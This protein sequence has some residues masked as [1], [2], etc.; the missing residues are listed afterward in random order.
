M[1][2]LKTRDQVK[3]EDTWDLTQI[4][5]TEEDWKAACRRVEQRVPELN[6][7]VGQLNSAAQV[8]SCMDMVMT[9]KRDVECVM[10]YASLLG[11]TDLGDSQCQQLRAEATNLI[12]KLAMGIAFITPELSA[13]SDAFLQSCLTDPT[14]AEYDMDFRRL[15]REKAHI[16][17]DAEEKL[18]ARGTPLWEDV[19]NIYEKLES[20]DIT[21][22]TARDSNKEPHLVTH[23]SYGKLMESPDRVLRRNTHISMFG[24]FMGL[25][26]TCAATLN[27]QVKQH[28][29]F[30]EIRS[31]KNTLE[32]AL[33]H[34][35]IDE[36][37][38]HTLILSTEKNAHLLHKYMEIRQRQLKLNEM[39]M[40]DLHVPLVPDLAMKFSYDEA[41]EMILKAFKP[42]GDDYVQ[43]LRAGMTT[44]R[45]VDKYENKGKRSGAFSSGCYDTL[46]YILM[47]YNDTLDNVYTL[48]HEAGHS[49]HSYLARK[50][51]PATKSEYTIF[52][53][54]IASTVNERLLTHYLLENYEGE[55]RR[56]VLNREMD[57]IRATFFRQTQFA[58][59]ERKIHQRVEE[60]KA[61][62]A[63]WLCD[64]YE[65]LNARYYGPAMRKNE[66]TPYEWSRIPHFYNNYY[67]FQYATGIACAYHFADQILKGNTVPYLELLKSGGSD[68]PL[69][70]LKKAGVDMHDSGVYEPLFNRFRELMKVFE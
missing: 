23:G 27:A 16:L 18:L 31:Y 44:E 45:W 1:E 22:P 43:I 4:F 55:T 3:T 63:D 5:A 40:W 34:K 30:A 64:L 62:T 28:Q 51:Q 14:L 50:H 10:M 54:E 69:D 12:A 19:H 37:V 7:F 6:A 39:E 60:G 9:L 24:Q 61:L 25:A 65:D 11:V 67:V 32:S 35:A 48:A 2:K 57:G 15:I 59:F 21:F 46:P 68:F 53:A 20:V 47:N 42:L 49:M 58:N 38:Y 36:G 13:K 33:Y 70:Q 41:V 17:S 8:K 26:H 66:Y 52:V 56:Y 29:F